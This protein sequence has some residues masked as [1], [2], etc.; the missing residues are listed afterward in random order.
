MDFVALFATGRRTSVF[1]AET[2]PYR[3]DADPRAAV[4]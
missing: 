3:E 4:I 1:N 2:K